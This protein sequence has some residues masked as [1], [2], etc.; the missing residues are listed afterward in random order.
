MLE[1]FF[2]KVE[3]EDFMAFLKEV[4]GET[5]TNSLGRYTQEI[6]GQYSSHLGRVLGLLLPPTYPR[7]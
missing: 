2:V 3:D 4:T 7:I 5:S 6:S 1:F